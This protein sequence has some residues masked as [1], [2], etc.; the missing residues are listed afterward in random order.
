MRLIIYILLIFISNIIGAQIYSI[1]YKVDYSLAKEGGVLDLK[2]ELM[3]LDTDGKNSLFRPLEEKEIDSLNILK[4]KK[5]GFNFGVEHQFYIKKNFVK[6]EIFKIISHGNEDYCLPINGI[7]QWDLISEK[8]TINGFHV[9]KAIGV[10]GGRKWTAWFDITFPIN[11]GPYVFRGLPGL[12]I[13]IYD[14]SREYSFTLVQIKKTYNLFDARSK[15][16]LIDWKKYE[17]LAK[18]HYNN[19]MGF[20]ILSDEIISL[21]DEN[22]NSIDITEINRS[23]QKKI[24]KQNNPIEL[25][26]KINYK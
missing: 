25:D 10:Y 1:D 11:D 9:Q 7:I 18:T 16:I 23:L 8:K 14:E 3:I 19:P 6:N 13:Q 12:I 26:H 24:A 4:H 17:N 15:T 22:G 5:N 21:T 2:S 20:N